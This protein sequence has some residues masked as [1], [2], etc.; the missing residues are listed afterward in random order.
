M[1]PS[2]QSIREIVTTQPSATRVFERFEIDLSSQADNS[3]EGA[4]AELQL[5][6]DQVLEKL[7]DAQNEESGATAPDPANLPLS[8]LIQ[9]IVRVH[10]HNVRQE[11]P[12]LTEMAAK[13]VTKKGDRAPELRRVTE[14]LEKLHADMLAHIQKE[15]QVLFP[16]IAQ[17]DRDSIITYP[18]AHACF[19]SVSFPISMMEQEHEAAN[20]IMA[21]LREI[22]QGF[23]PPEWACVTHI[24]LFAGICEFESDL[25]QHVHL[26]NDVLFQRAIKLEAELNSRG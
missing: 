19:R 17:M 13:V 7:A 4:C 22:T 25:R 6:V 15:E 10:H 5:S 1:Y 23:E 20:H 11:L 3:L 8:R 9:H 2:T 18:P 12:R 14:L 24:A 26:E 16:F 21:E